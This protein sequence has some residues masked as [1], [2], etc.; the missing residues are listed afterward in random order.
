L[1]LGSA[2]HAAA[3]IPERRD[4]AAARKAENPFP[5]WEMVFS[6]LGR[7]GDLAALVSVRSLLRD[8]APPASNASTAASV[9][10]LFNR[11]F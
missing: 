11:V 1:A 7:A 9:M 2:G 10:I 3:A 4:V 5:T 6:P 8:G